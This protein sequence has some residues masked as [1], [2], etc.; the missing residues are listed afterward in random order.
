MLQQ[1]F[2]VLDWELP[3]KANAFMRVNARASLP[4]LWLKAAAY[5]AYENKT[6]ILNKTDACICVMLSMQAS[7]SF[8]D[9][10]VSEC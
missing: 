8:G 4:R 9:N 5:L 1:S 2:S 6:G 7:V 10:A 3:S